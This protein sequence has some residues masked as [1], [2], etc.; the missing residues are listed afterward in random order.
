MATSVSANRK[1]AS[2]HL[3]IRVYM[4]NRILHVRWWIRI[5][6]SRVQLEISLV[7]CAYLKEPLKIKCVSTRGHVISSIYYDWPLSKLTHFDIFTTLLRRTVA[8]K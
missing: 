2:Q 3:A 7:R 1:R 4:I 8:E 5:S 6:S